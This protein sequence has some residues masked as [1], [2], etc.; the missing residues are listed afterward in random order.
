MNIAL[1]SVVAEAEGFFIRGF[2][3]VRI[4]STVTKAVTKLSKTDT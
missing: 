3:C 4:G 1:P 2:L